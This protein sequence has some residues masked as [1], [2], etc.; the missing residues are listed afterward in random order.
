[1]QALS[2]S[3]EIKVMNRKLDAFLRVDT[4]LEVSGRQYI[5]FVDN[6]KNLA[7]LASYRC[8]QFQTTALNA[9]ETS[10]FDTSC[11]FKKIQDFLYKT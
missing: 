7:E 3:F 6:D 4:V 9:N 11:L 5:L 2:T 10:T 1:M 8:H